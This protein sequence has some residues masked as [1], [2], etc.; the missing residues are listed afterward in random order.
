MVILFIKKLMGCLQGNILKIGVLLDPKLKGENN[1]MA[2]KIDRTQVYQDGCAVPDDSLL[3]IH[4]LSGSYVFRAG[5]VYSL[6]NREI[7]ELPE[8]YLVT[9][10]GSST[11]ELQPIK[12]RKKLA[13]LRRAL[14]PPAFVPSG[15]GRKVAKIKTDPGMSPSQEN[16]VRSLEDI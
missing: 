15:L 2:I 7:A 9:H 3:I 6:R 4:F 12:N 10:S 5:D 1:K 11:L 8:A 16:A 13:E 14:N